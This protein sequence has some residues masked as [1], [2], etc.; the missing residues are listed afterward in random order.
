MKRDGEFMQAFNDQIVVDE[1]NQIIIAE[2]VTN[3][4]PDQEHLIPLM[5]RAIQNLSRTPGILSADCG[6]MSEDNVEYCE[7]LGIDAHIA[8]ERDKHGKTKNGNEEKK[9]SEVWQAMRKK[10]TSEEGRK[11]YSR[12]KVIVEPVF[13]NI[14]EPRNFRR[15]SLRGLKK[16]RREFTLVCLCHNLHKLLSRVDEIETAGF[17]A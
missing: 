11:I 14:K 8:V 15:F 10:L 9:E 7:N 1:A 3:Q 17:R 2:A 4:S 16:I 6:Y 13:G 5:D 12:R